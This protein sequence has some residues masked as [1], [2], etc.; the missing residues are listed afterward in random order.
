MRELQNR[1]YHFY[2]RVCLR[3][4]PKRRM[5]YMKP[6]TCQRCYLLGQIEKAGMEEG[7]EEIKLRED[8]EDRE[9]REETC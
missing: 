9:D 4:L 6:G 7:M 2:C 1:V 3:R 8:R 5:S